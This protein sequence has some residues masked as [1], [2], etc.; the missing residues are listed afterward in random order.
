MAKRRGRVVIKT[1]GV[2]DVR[3][4]LRRLEIAVGAPEVVRIMQ[5]GAGL[6]AAAVSARAPQGPTG[7][8]RKSVYTASKL[9]NN[10]KPL[11]RRGKL[12][13]KPLKHLPKGSLV[14]VTTGAFYTKF[15][16]KGKKTR[17]GPQLKARQH[18]KGGVGRM[19][20]RPF[21]RA[22]INSS[23]PLASAFIVRRLDRFL[24]EKAR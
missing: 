18:R 17:Q 23:R 11:S 22:A 20:A 3:L 7:N 10:Y 12:V 24:Q 5:E 21:F 15:V 2:A 4:M 14:L 1:E 6:M 13:T 19:K 8:L 9:K 16:E